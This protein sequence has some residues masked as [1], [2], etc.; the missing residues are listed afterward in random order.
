MTAKQKS[1][2]ANGA[3]KYQHSYNSNF[4]VPEQD[5]I[6]LFKRE[7]DSA[8]LSTKDKIIADGKL[9]R[10]HVHG[11]RPGSKNGW[12]V[13][14]LG[15]LT[16]GAFGSWKSSQTHKWCAKPGNTLTKAE[17]RD[18]TQRMKIAAK[19]RADE[20]AE[21]Y[22]QAQRK[23]HNIL[24]SATAAPDDHPYLRRKGVKSHNA[25][26][27]KGLLT[28]PMRDSAGVLHSLQFI[29]ADGNKNYLGGGHV[30]GCYFA[31]GTP[32]DTICLCEG[33]ATA[34]SVHEATGHATAVAF[35]AGNL[36]PVARALRAKFPAINIILCA[37]ND[38]ETDGNPGL[39]KAREAAAAV[40]GLLT[41]AKK[42]Y[43]EDG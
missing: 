18:L 25:R 2:A 40:G 23:A 29:D 36:L 30:R 21:G 14:F 35:S 27:Y 24:K 16:A 17:K 9:H 22:K 31:I 42:G 38:T 11:D 12:Y 10:F 33:F 7:M 1:P 37:D 13:L 3:K 34:A 26:L 43:H 20:I 19:A 39:T 5:A 15:G 32:T 6:A 8:G 4:H 28:I 41:V